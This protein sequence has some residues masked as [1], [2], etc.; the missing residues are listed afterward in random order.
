MNSN[1][2]HFL[3]FRVGMNPHGLSEASNRA[4]NMGKQFGEVLVCF[5]LVLF[6]FVV[7]MIFNYYKRVI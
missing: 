2:L 7:F 5:G 4:Q 1:D 3:L 6:C